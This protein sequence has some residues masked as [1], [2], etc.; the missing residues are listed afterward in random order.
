MTKRKSSI[1]RA[2]KLLVFTSLK[3][4][5][6]DEKVIP[7]FHLAKTPIESTAAICI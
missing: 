3:D 6:P 2:M 1:L 4:A 5:D 7:L